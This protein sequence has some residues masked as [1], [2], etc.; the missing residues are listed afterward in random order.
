LLPAPP[1]NKQQRDHAAQY[2]FP[3]SKHHLLR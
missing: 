3:F 1:E 2:C